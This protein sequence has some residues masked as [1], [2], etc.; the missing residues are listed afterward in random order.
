MRLGVSIMPRR[1]EDPFTCPNC[2]ARASNPIR[3]WTLVSPIPDKY[4]RVTVT[5]MGAFVCDSCGR[6][7]SSPIQKIKS[8]GEE[9]R[10]EV[11]GEPETIVIDIEELKK[12]T[13]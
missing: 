3:T 2:G 6:T 1:R 9:R 4:G 8:G 13:L 5:V 11:S 7:W 10:V 12:E